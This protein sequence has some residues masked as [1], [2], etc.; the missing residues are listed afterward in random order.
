MQRKR[1]TFARWCV[2]HIWG[3][4]YFSRQS[5]FQLVFP[6]VQRFS[7]CT[8]HRSLLGSSPSGSRVIRRWG[9]NRRPG[10]NLFNYRYIER[11]ETDSVV[12]ELMEKR[13][14]NNWFTWN[15]NHHLRRPQASLHSPEGEKAL[16]P[17]R[18]DLRSPSTV[19]RLGA[20]PRT[21]WE[22]SQ[23]NGEQERN[24]TVESVFPE[25]DPISLFFRFA[26][27]PFCYT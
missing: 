19:S 23:E 13:R 25:T 9:R 27:I 5:W 22:F 26:Y 11:L 7:W 2:L 6:P 14:L 24:D 4:W 3:Y 15:T 21:R 20:Y 18:S 12:G 8:L 17:P 10:I 16:R 1:D